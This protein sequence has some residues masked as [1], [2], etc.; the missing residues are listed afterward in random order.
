MKKVLKINETYVLQKIENKFLIFYPDNSIL[1]NLNESASFILE[2][3]Q[4]GLAPE[5][6]TAGYQKF[7]DV[8]SDRAKLDIQTVFDY[9]K[10]ENI[11]SDY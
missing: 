9:L 5:T 8:S 7:Y 11:L 6:I 1:Y 3:I 10:K 4:K 2:G